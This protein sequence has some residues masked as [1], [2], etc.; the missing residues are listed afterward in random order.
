VRGV[1]APHPQG[2]SLTLT[3]LLDQ[4]GAQPRFCAP[5]VQGGEGRLGGRPVYLA[6]TDPALARG[7]I[8]VAEAHALGEL[9]RQARRSRHP[10]VLLLDSAGARVD[11]G[12]AALGA[13][14]RLF[15]EALLTRLAGVPMLALL[16]RSCFGGASML[17]CVCT[18]R[19]FR[20]DSRLG[21][22]GPAVVEA[23]EGSTRFHS[24][25]PV[26]VTALFGAQSRQALLQD[27]LYDV[28]GEQWLGVATQWLSI[29][30]D[31]SAWNPQAAHAS[32]ERR[33]QRHGMLAAAE[34]ADA[35]LQ[36]RVALLLPPGYVAVC[37]GSVFSAAPGPGRG[38]AV[39]GGCVSGR[40]VTARDCWRLSERLMTLGLEH[41]GSPI[42]LVLDA[43]AHA[44]TVADESVLLSEYLVH[45]SMVIA[46]LARSG[47]RTALWLPGAASGAAYV[48]FASPADRVSVLP[49]A[50]VSILPALAQ[51]RIIGQA[52]EPAMDVQ[53]VL[54]AGVADA[55][56][57]SRLDAYA[58][59]RPTDPG[60]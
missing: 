44:A 17:A 22:S 18:R 28:D 42:V 8:G 10:V 2:V 16:G 7:A 49:S 23:R 39:F 54:A 45:L 11:E 35:A 52:L 48:A 31:A 60:E 47:H 50:R 32:L 5:G 59:R 58:R 27:D 9:F 3:K 57:D 51:Q 1:I 36:D 29:A 30:S 15:R 20:S 53:S 26:Q 46:Q 19:A 25:D 41:P 33:L 13:F 34:P 4:A 21:A 55:V 43:Q 37:E 38:K 12:L 6:A 14:R 56:L 40:T 24:K